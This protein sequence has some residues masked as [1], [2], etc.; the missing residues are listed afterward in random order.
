MIGEKE[1]SQCCG[2]YACA[3]RCP[4]HCISMKSDEEG[5]LYPTIRTE[6]CI[7][8]GLCENVCP[9]THKPEKKNGLQAFAVYCTDEKIRA[10][11]SSGGVFTLL[12]EAV[13]KENGVVFG[14]AFQDDCQVIHSSARTREAVAAFRGS[15]YVQSLLNNTYCEAKEYLDQGRLVLYSGT[16][17]QIAGL[18]AYLGMDYDNLLCQDIVCHGVPSPKVWAKYVGELEKKHGAPVQPASFRNKALGW[19]KYRMF[20]QFQ[21]G[22]SYSN[23]FSGDP[24]MKV[25]LANLSL[26]PSCYCCAFK[27]SGE[28]SDVT[29]ADFWGL[30]EVIPEMD[31][32]RGVSL[33]IIRSDKGKSYLEKISCQIVRK[34]IDLQKVIPYNPSIV[35]SVR[36][37]PKRKEFF[38]ALDQEKMETLAERYCTEPYAKR[39]FDRLT[40][41]GKSVIFRAVRKLRGAYRK[42]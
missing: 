17:C 19:K 28:T 20:I 33:L 13:L 21:N 3:S 36:E 39:A 31:D 29:L 30:E 11:S 2:C 4:R 38:T 23:C 26:R 6:E 15:K 27:Q 42:G 35:E 8:C 32:D 37:H 1:K 10:E 12:A 14:A 9:V 7:G 5:F 34:E 25:F 22:D 16:P 18:K 40:A 41:M 24:F